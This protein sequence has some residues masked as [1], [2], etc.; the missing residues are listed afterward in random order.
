[1][2][3]SP[4]GWDNDSMP[5]RMQIASSD[6][7]LLDKATRVAESFAA[8]FMRDDMAGIAFLGAVAR[9]YFDRFADIDIALFTR[10]TPD[11][12]AL[13]QCLQVDG[14]EVHPH[15][16]CIDDES[17]STWD[18]PKRWAFSE[19]RIYHD[20]EGRISR[21]LREKVPL[22]PEERR[23]LLISGITLSE[24]YIN[25]LASAWIERGS[26]VSAHS[27]FN[28]G[29]NH[30]TTMLF[31]LNN[32]LVA[33]HKW[34]YYYAERLEVVPSDFGLRMRNV[35]ELNAFTTEEIR[36]RQDDF[37]GMWRQML[38]LVEKDVRMNYEDFKDT[39]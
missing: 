31:S 15:V 37:M 24:W 10:N 7:S 6:P 18:M 33:D 25:R 16:A 14:F 19:S 4:R 11:G 17:A 22:R 12:L 1:M 30:F 20:P 23:W 32:Q 38:P 21:L 36:R 26:I 2:D 8:R 35:M 29:L 13:P 9:G 28:E 27:M 34:R 3:N 39:V 5:N